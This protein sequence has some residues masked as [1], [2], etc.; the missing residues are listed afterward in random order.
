[1]P[2]ENRIAVFLF[3]DLIAG[4]HSGRNRWSK[5]EYSCITSKS[6]AKLAAKTEKGRNS[7]KMDFSPETNQELGRSKQ[8]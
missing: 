8:K 5:Q 2:N 1:V 3:D 6:S 4:H 7:C